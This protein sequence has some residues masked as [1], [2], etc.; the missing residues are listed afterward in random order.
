[1]LIP[2]LE[3]QHKKQQAIFKIKSCGINC[4]LF[5]Q[6]KQTPEF[7][8]VKSSLK[9]IINTRLNHQLFFVCLFVCLFCFVFLFPDSDSIKWPLAACFHVQICGV[10]ATKRTQSKTKDYTDAHMT[11]TGKDNLV[12]QLEKKNALWPEHHWPQDRKSVV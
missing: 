1:M 5:L 6:C 7:G 2:C 10:F 8:K 11:K 12:Y 3:T 4:V 9:S